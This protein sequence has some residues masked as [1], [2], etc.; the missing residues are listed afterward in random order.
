MIMTGQSCLQLGSLPVECVQSG[1]FRDTLLYL[2]F[3]VNTCANPTEVGTFCG[4]ESRL[5]LRGLTWKERVEMAGRSW[6][7]VGRSDGGTSWKAVSS[8]GTEMEMRVRTSSRYLE[9][10]AAGQEGSH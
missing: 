2:I 1:A 4:L 5:L 7:D 8:L 3:S 6:D 10:D 9:T